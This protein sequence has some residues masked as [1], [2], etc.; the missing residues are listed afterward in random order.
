MLV[1]ASAVGNRVNP[2][3]TADGTL[4]LLDDEGYAQDAALNDGYS[5]QLMMRSALDAI[6]PTE[7]MDAEEAAR[8][9]R[10]IGAEGRAKFI[11]KKFIKG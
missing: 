9:Y 10:E 3:V 5:T 1:Y 8:A 11:E 2:Y 4:R 6:T 7:Q